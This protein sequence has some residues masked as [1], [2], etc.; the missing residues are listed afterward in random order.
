M[1]TFAPVAAMLADSTPGRNQTASASSA[2]RRLLVFA[3]PLLLVAIGLGFALRARVRIN[4]SASDHA[5]APEMQSRVV[6]LGYLSPGEAIVHLSA[7][8]SAGETRIAELRVRENDVVKKGDVVAVL[9][10]V[11]KLRASLLD[12]KAQAQMKRANL[13]RVLA[14]ASPHDV[15]AQQATVDRLQ[16]ELMKVRGDY[17]RYRTL[18]SEGIASDA[19]WEIR[20]AA[21]DETA[22]QLTEAR[23]TLHKV[24]EVRAVDVEVARADLQVAEAAV[25]EA[26]ASLSQAFVRAPEAGQVLRI[27]VRPGERIADQ[28][29]L[30][31][32]STQ[33]MY[34]IAEVYETDAAKLH[35]GQR[36]TIAS[37][38]LSGTLAGFVERVGIEVGRQD[39]VN[40]DPAANTDARVVRVLVRLEPPSSK[41]AAGFTNLQVTVSFAP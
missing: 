30:D 5:L 18:H 9:D 1:I 10:N 15:G 34:A 26:K 14:G 31:I 28:G 11:A 27:N 21:F 23:S 36:A 6:A 25:A 3:L 39:V 40:A 7:P 33:R 4:A 37:T 29:I 41:M 24:A 12:A 16:A 22:Q 19:D 35:A 38:S 17:E 32:G 8:A 2:R 13:E 20:K